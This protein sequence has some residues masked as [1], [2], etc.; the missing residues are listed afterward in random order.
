MKILAFAGH[1]V[2][3]IAPYPLT[4]PIENFTSIYR[5]IN[6]SLQEKSNSISSF[7]SM[8]GH[9]LRNFNLNIIEKYCYDIT[10]LEEIQVLR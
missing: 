6:H 5:Y 3:I 4:T 9:Q 2:T 8:S 10:E 7:K 1:N